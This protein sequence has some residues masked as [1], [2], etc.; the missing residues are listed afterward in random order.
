MSE[1]KTHGP[2]RLFYDGGCG[3]CH[4]AVNFVIARDPD[5]ALFRFTPLESELLDRS[6]PAGVTRQALPD[7]VL[8]LTHDG[9]LLMRSD[10]ALYLGERVGGRWRIAA[11]LGRLVPR[12]LRDAVYDAIA[13]TRHR[14]F[15][16][17]TDACPL[18][19]PELRSRFDL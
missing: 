16:K 5:G 11:K 7:S 17:P 18:L 4:R 10:A 3:L 15:A 13:S 2:E 1:H 9:R 14:L 6:L 12:L 19:P 8:V